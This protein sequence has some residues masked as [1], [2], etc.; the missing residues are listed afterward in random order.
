MKL[1]RIYSIMM[2]VAVY[3]LGLAAGITAP[4]GLVE[5]YTRSIRSIVLQAYSLP[6]VALYV[7]IFSNNLI[8]ALVSF[9][10]G[11]AILPPLLILFINGLM[12]GAVA[13]TFMKWYTFLEFLSLILPHGIFEIP[14]FILACSAGIDVSMIVFERGLREAARAVGEEAA[15]LIPVILL[16]AIAAAIETALIYAVR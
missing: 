8:V 14:A 3:A 5:S 7:L 1:P 16:L 13:T 12:L 10:G 9:I 11:L 15:K 6:P 4:V 2:A